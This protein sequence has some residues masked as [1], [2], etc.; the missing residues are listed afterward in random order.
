M[1]VLSFIMGSPHPRWWA[2]DDILSVMA[3]LVPA[4]PMS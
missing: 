3:G 1:A 4:I 2:E